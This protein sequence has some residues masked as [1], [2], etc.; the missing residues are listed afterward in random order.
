MMSKSCPTLIPP[1]PPCGAT[2][3]AVVRWAAKQYGDR[4]LLVLGEKRISFIEA[5]HQSAA[6]AKGLVALG[7]GKGTRVGI[8]MENAP[9]WPLCF[10]AAA[11]AGALTVSL[12]TFY[13][14]PEIAWA[15]RHNDVDTLLVTARYL[16]AD[17]IERL[18]RALPGLQ[19]HTDTELYLPGHPFLRRIVVF[20]GCDRPWAIKGADSILAAAAAKPQIGDA[21][22]AQVEKNIVPADDLIII[23]TSGSTAEPKAVLHT[24]GVCIRSTY[25]F[26][27]YM[28]MR[29]G[30][31]SYNGL[32]FFWIGGHNINLMPALYLGGTLC[33]APTPSADAIFDTIQKERV[34]RVCLWPTQIPALLERAEGRD[35]STVRTGLGEPRDPWGDVI[36]RDRRLAG[37]LGM[38]ESFGMHSI[39]RTW[40]P[41]PAG[42][43]GS[44]GQTVR[45]ME[46]RIVDPATGAD[47]PRGTEG[48][49]YIRGYSMMKGYYR[50][51]REECV[52]RDGWF[53]TGD[54]AI[55]DEDDHIFFTGRLGELVKTS[56]ANVAPREV[57]LALQR[58]PGVRE[59]IAFG[60]PD[61]VKG[62]KVVAVL[63]AQS[64][65]TLD[66]ADIMARLKQDVSPY[67][68]PAEFVVMTFDDIPRTG[69]QKPNKPQLK[70]MVAAILDQR[71]T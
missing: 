1:G 27:D 17:Y 9:D 28:D 65:V 24:H 60:L 46:R 43:G 23:C 61:A 5:E 52:T 47:L 31:R 7:I 41:T 67:K 59:A 11:R 42:K 44:W 48:E 63:I 26:L 37:V 13:Q 68:V 50:K 40:L 29:P 71:E 56:G 69:S 54:L 55:I 35:L 38:T 20:G 34:T 30:D 57:E 45:G 16:A 10:F 4:E 15:L 36:P 12:S 21:F 58:L 64:D 3:P 22:L 33:F 62:E 19:E 2:L 18:E 14:A 53:A 66:V 49:L 70:T 8:L 51:E 39:Y 6:L 25:D 32:P